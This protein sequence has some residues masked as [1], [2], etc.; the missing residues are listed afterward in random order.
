[1]FGLSFWELAV[2][3]VVAL[4]VLGPKKLPE[5]AKSL[6]KGLQDLRRASVD[7]KSAI[8]EPMEEVRR[9]L[10]DLRRDFVQAVH[11]FGREIDKA[12]A[13]VEAGAE[14]G[15]GQLTDGL[16]PYEG[17]LPPLAVGEAPSIPAATE[18]VPR[19][20]A[21]AEEARRLEEVEALYAASRPAE[22]GEA[23]S[24]PAAPAGA[25]PGGEGE[26]AAEGAPVEGV[27]SP[28]PGAGS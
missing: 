2:I 5:L 18:A 14:D 7:L 21:E 16:P 3:L 6:G 10:E 11:G 25:T 24:E 1:M 9:P 23:R 17:D 22:D 20:G 15:T 28:T 27:R 13:S 26:V 19:L 8:A 4:I 12:A